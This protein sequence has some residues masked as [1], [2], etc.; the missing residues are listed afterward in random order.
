MITRNIS[1]TVSSSFSKIVRSNL[2]WW[3]DAMNDNS[4]PE[5]GTTWTDLSGNGNSGTFKPSPPA[6]SDNFNRADG[7]LGANWETI[8]GTTAPSII[9][10]EVRYVG[11]GTFIFSGARVATTALTFG[12]NQE[13]SVTLRGGANNSIGPAVRI[14]SGGTCYFVRSQVGSSV[15]LLERFNGTTNS[16]SGSFTGCPTL[17]DGDV[18]KLKVEGTSF[19]LFVNGTQCGSSV[20][21]TTYASGQPGFLQF[22]F[23]G[24]TGA[25]IDN[26]VAT[27]ISVVNAPTF[28]SAN[29]GSLVFDGVNHISIPYNSGTFNIGTSDFTFC[30]WYYQTSS[31]LYQR[32][33][34][35]GLFATA[36]N[37]EIE[38]PGTDI[39]VHVNGG[40][41]TYTAASA[42]NTWRHLVVSRI[43]G[44]VTTYING[45][46]IGT[47]A[48][49]GTI[50]NTSTPLLAAYDG[51]GNGLIGRVAS[52]Q[53]YNGLG[54]SSTQALQNYYADRRRFGL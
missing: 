28:N 15:T 35:L 54:L 18:I 43:S 6:F 47:N 26:F 27:E 1:G 33:F 39:L 38:T 50:N 41:L 21:D 20:T 10:N 46:S 16:N 44:N 42:I 3:Y 7:G 13:A 17:V 29:G 40:Y 45:T 4:Y 14:S 2:V 8:T 24:T 36:G 48:Q 51:T 11:A 32:L 49:T 5:S 30:A 9:T 23:S 19:T 31:A 25:R 52:V 22:H 12:V 37:F 34:S 53:L